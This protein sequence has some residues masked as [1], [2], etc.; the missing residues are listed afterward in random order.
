MQPHHVFPAHK[1]KE[2]FVDAALATITAGAFC[3]LLY[4]LFQ[5]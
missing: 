1:W 2:Y 4:R 3:A 5:N